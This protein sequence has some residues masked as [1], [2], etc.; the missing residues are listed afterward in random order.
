[1]TRQPNPAQVV[2]GSDNAEFERLFRQLLP[3]ARR[4]AHRILRDETDAEDAAAEA[5]ARAH[6]SWHKVGT[7]AYREAW[8][9]RVTSNIAID[10]VRK[11]RPLMVPADDGGHEESSALHVTLVGE[12]RAL[13]RRQREIVALRYLH[14]FSEAEVATVLRVSPGTVKKTTYRAM[15]ALRARLGSTFDEEVLASVEGTLDAAN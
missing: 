7:L 15:A 2:D 10:I 14:G 3:Q 4:V 11:R 6:A 12:L 8:I 13:P 9:L 5:F 1:M